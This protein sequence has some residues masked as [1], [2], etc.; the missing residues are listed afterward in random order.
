MSMK[1]SICIV[2]GIDLGTTNTCVSYFRDY[3]PEIL[4]IE[5]EQTV[6][7]IVAYDNGKWMIGKHAK[8]ITSKNPANA[9]FSIKRQMG[10]PNYSI[11]I[12]EERLDPTAISSKILSYLKECIKRDHNLELSNVVITVPAYFNDSQRRATLQ[13]GIEVGLNVL[14]IINEPTAASLLY[15]FALSSTWPTHSL[16]SPPLSP[17]HA[18]KIIV[19]DLGG[20]T[21]DV[22]VLLVKQGQYEVLASTGNNYLGGDDFDLKIAHF[23]CDFIKIN[24]GI[25]IDN[26]LQITKLKIL[27]ENIK[28]KLSDLTEVDIDE[29]IQIGNKEIKLKLRITRSQ[30]EAMITPYVESTIEKTNE[31]LREANCTCDEISKFLLVG[32]STRIPLLKEKLCT[33]FGKTISNYFDPDISVALGASIQ[34]AICAGLKVDSIII[35]VSSHTLGVAAMGEIDSLVES[36]AHAKVKEAILAESQ[37]HANTT[38]DHP[39]NRHPKTF[40]PVILRGTRLPARNIKTFYTSFDNQEHVEVAIYQGESK[41][42]LENLFIGSFS[43]NLLPSSAGT[44]IHIRME[45]DL[46]GIVKINIAQNTCDNNIYHYHFNLNAPSSA[47]VCEPFTLN[48][49]PFAET[50]EASRQLLLFLQKNSPLCSHGIM[51]QGHALLNDYLSALK[52][53]DDDRLD[54]LEITIHNFIKDHE[55]GEHQ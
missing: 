11:T 46:N 41:S 26:S 6:P 9:I 42:T 50:N 38:N 40:V 34:A 3:H 22:T 25:A 32:G 45:Y 16:L 44:P 14:R 43:V 29:I 20:G 39:G 17:L 13:A 12:N 1:D 7:S 49:S 30:F 27:A 31:A 47:T 35:D 37:Q 23:L 19:F 24:H 55:Q 8:N 53:A 21:F 4:P 10:N 52:C 54:S 36:T 2:F 51:E 33:H 5:G 18:E 48:N 28:I 15:N